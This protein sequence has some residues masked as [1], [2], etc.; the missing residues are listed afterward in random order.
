[1]KHNNHIIGTVLNEVTKSSK[2][3]YASYYGGNYHYSYEG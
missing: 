2:S 1:M 3:G